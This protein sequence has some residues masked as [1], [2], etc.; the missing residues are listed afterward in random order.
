MRQA[1]DDEGE[2]VFLNEPATECVPQLVNGDLVDPGSRARD[3]QLVHRI[4]PGAQELA[5]ACMRRNAEERLAQCPSL[6]S[7]TA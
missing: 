3:L 6:T 4:R 7:P 1:S 2:H 5:D